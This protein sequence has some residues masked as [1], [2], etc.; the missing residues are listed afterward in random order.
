[1][2]NMYIAIIDYNMGNIKSVQNA[3]STQCID[4]RV[5]KDPDVVKNASA[6]I[7]PGVGAFGDAVK[8][9][10]SMGLDNAIK[11]IIRMKKPFLGICIGLQVLFEYGTEGKKSSGLGIFGG[12]VFR[13]TGNVKIPHMGWNSI[14]ILKK[15]SPIFKGIRDGESFYFVH[16]YSAVPSDAGIVS[17]MTEYENEIISSVEQNNV[18]GLQFHPEK[19]SLSGL[20]ILKNF[21]DLAINKQGRPY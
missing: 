13:L 14:R 16:S 15:G 21:A 7:L 4:A 8:N 18:F 12:T 17:S 3:L 1:M 5:T 2:N 6:V 20:K 9:L 11:E 19:S 10:K